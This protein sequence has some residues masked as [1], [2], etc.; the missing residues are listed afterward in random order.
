MDN[1]HEYQPV[2]S[3][4]NPY[5][6]IFIDITKERCLARMGKIRLVMEEYGMPVPP[7][8]VHFGLVLKRGIMGYYL[9]MTGR[10]NRK[11]PK[12]KHPQSSFLHDLLNIDIKDSALFNM[13]SFDKAWLFTDYVKNRTLRA[14]EDGDRTFLRGLGEAISEEPKIKPLRSSPSKAVSD[15][16]QRL[17]DYAEALLDSSKTGPS[18]TKLPRGILHRLHESVCEEK[19]AA[20]FPDEPMGEQ[21]FYRFIRRN[22]ITISPTAQKMIEKITPSYSQ[23]K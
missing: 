2:G 9:E 7:D 18:E 15:N 10:Y 22:F 5:M 8:H 11:Y 4:A 23:E 17:L 19:N 3:D 13:V 16:H 21:T 6:R 20:W 1:K 12:K 14:Q